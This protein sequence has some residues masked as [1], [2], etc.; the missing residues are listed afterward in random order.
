VCSPIVKTE[1]DE[2]DVT[3]YLHDLHLLQLKIGCDGERKSDH[4]KLLT[5]ERWRARRARPLFAIL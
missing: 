1:V 4:L 5:V 3:V 2:M